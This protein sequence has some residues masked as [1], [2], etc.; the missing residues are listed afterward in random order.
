MVR[1]ENLHHPA[2]IISEFRDLSV[3]DLEQYSLK[4]FLRLRMVYLLIMVRFIDGRSMVL[5]RSAV[6]AGASR[7][8]CYR[9]PLVLWMVNS[10][11][12]GNGGPF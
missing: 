1:L 5:G 8:F 4:R 11:F 7:W 3:F 10:P 12:N 2:R 6:L 9:T